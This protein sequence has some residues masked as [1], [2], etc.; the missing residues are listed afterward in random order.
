MQTAAVSGC[1][2]QLCTRDA[3]Q[4]D[5][6]ESGWLTSIRKVPGN[7]P[8]WSGQGDFINLRAAVQE[9]LSPHSWHTEG[10]TAG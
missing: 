10:G 2:M 4:H 3:G 8:F 5:C 7:V 1:Q 6:S 9:E